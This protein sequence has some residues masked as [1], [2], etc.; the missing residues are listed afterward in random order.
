[1]CKVKWWTLVVVVGAMLPAKFIDVWAETQQYNWLG[2]LYVVAVAV[3]LF[4]GIIR[5]LSKG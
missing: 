4:W 1:M 3:L 5:P 2:A